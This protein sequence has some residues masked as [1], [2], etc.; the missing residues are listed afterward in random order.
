MTAVMLKKVK[1]TVHSLVSIPDS[2]VIRNYRDIQGFLSAREAL[3]LFQTARKLPPSATIVEIG[4]WKGKST[5]CLAKGL[6]AGRLI[7]IDPF[8]CFGDAASEVLY[9][10]TQGE[11]P[12][13]E[14]FRQNMFRRG[15]LDKIEIWKGLSPQF[16]DCLP[17]LG[18]IDLLFIDGDHSVE[19]AT[20]D[21]DNYGP[22][23]KTG[24][25]VLFHDFDKTREDLGP[26]WVINNRVRPS[27][28]W[29]WVA[30]YDSLWIGRRTECS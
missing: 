12:L 2:L 14:Q 21:F 5:Y 4:S 24:G 30:C 10:N 1:R 19:G 22:H 28:K 26:T 17:A 9:K 29:A 23:V 20:Y 13:V 27:K 25:Y 7:A 16:V 11:L 15:V 3:G 8:N 6:S 18:E